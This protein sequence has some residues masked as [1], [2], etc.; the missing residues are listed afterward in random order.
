MILALST[1]NDTKIRIENQLERFRIK[2]D[3]GFESLGKIQKWCKRVDMN[4][5]TKLP[6]ITWLRS[7]TTT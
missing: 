3:Q 4:K 7:T 1:F 6:Q 5:H 2:L